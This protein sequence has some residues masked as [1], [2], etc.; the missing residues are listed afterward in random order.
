M[1]PRIRRNSFSLI[2]ASL[3]V[4]LLA[5][6]ATTLRAEPTVSNVL[7]RDNFTSK[8][9]TELMLKLRAITGWSTL[10]F[11]SAGSLRVGKG[12]VMRGSS[13]ARKLISKA[14]SGANVIVLDESLRTRDVVFCEVLLT[15]W[16][17]AASGKPPV[18]VLRID[19]DDFDRVIGDLRARQAF[20][21]A[22]AV[23]HELDHVVNESQDSP[24]FGAPGECETNIN[25]MRRELN[26]AE[27]VG[28]FFTFLTTASAGD[29]KSRFVRMAFQQNDAR[30]SKP[31]RYWLLWDAELVGGLPEARQ[32][33]SMR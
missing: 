11:D 1:Q 2:H 15:Q 17:Q 7:I 6:G 18:Y 28:Y 5:L 16:T 26:L 14:I 10:D 12:E 24:S 3:A 19:F 23:L 32:I 4:C 33:A 8:N 13:A 29:F 20:D 25:A 9:R 30:T 22:W 27:R 21:V 31:K